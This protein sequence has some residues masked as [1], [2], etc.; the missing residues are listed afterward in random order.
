MKAAAVKEMLIN[1]VV[2]TAIIGVEGRKRLAHLK[3][4]N[5]VA[6]EEMAAK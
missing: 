5:G 4:E 3:G 6:D 2:E 1:G